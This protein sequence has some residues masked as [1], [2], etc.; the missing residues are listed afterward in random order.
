MS[1]KLPMP[2][3]WCGKENS[4]AERVAKI[5]YGWRW[6]FMTKRQKERAIRKMK[7]EE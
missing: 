2:T 1:K 7:G 5:L 4:I 6:F 3:R